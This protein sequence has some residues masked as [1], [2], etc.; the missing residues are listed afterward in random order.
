M[1]RTAGRLRP[2]RMEPTEITDVLNRPLSRELLARDFARV[3]YVAKDGTPRVW[4]TADGREIAVLK[5]V[6]HAAFS[7][8][9]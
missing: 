8:D 7:P 5:G 3:A 4:D 2:R 9:G 1:S 6:R